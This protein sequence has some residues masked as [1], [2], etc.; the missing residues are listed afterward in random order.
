M[1]NIILG[2]LLTSTLL[3]ACPTK[4]EDIIKL[5]ESTQHQ[6]NLVQKVKRGEMKMGEFQEETIKS[7]LSDA[8]LI[9]HIAEVHGKELTLK[10]AEVL[11]N[12]N[13]QL[14]VELTTL[15]GNQL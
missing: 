15:V 14:R 1:R 4:R 7:M 12:I 6:Y 2:M 11:Q 10:E 3:S 8:K 9:G 13:N 5:E